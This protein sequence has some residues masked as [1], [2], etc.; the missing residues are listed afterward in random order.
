MRYGVRLLFDPGPAPSEEV[1][2]ATGL[3]VRGFY[4]ASGLLV[5]VRCLLTLL[6]KLAVIPL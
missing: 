1:A 6:L 3:Q 2:V 4:T 5:V